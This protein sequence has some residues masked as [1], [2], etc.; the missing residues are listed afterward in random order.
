[1]N[2]IEKEKAAKEFDEVLLERRPFSEFC[3]LFDRLIIYVCGFSSLSAS[4]HKVDNS[5]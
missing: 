5:V 1:M 4:C 2:E 3:N